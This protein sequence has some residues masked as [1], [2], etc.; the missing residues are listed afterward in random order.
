MAIGLLNDSIASGLD[1]CTQ[2]GVLYNDGALKL[3]L[4]LVFLLG[5]HRPGGSG[6]GDGD[7]D[8]LDFII[9]V[10]LVKYKE[11]LNTLDL[12][13]DFFFSYSYHIMTRTTELFQKRIYFKESNQ[14]WIFEKLPAYQCLDRISIS[15]KDIMFTLIARRSR[16]FAG[17]RKPINVLDVLLKVAF[18]ALRL[19]EFYS[20]LDVLLKVAFRAPPT[21]YSL[22]REVIRSMV[23]KQRQL[24]NATPLDVKSGSQFPV[25]ESGS[26]HGNE[27]SLTCESE[28][29]NLR[30]THPWYLRYIMFQALKL[31]VA[32]IQVIQTMDLEWLS[33]SGNLSDESQAVAVEAAS[34]LSRRIDAGSVRKWI[35]P[36]WRWF[37][38]SSSP[39]APLCASSPGP[40]PVHLAPELLRP[41]L[42]AAGPKLQ[43]RSWAFHTSSSSSEAAKRRASREAFFPVYNKRLRI[44]GIL[45]EC[46]NTKKLGLKLLE[47]DVIMN[48]IW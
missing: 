45:G 30:Y 20:V 36:S 48:F 24:L 41:R 4:P 18:R 40:S 13:K 46:Y 38:S 5:L 39:M 15:A 22:Q 10:D 37:L 17:T 19:T 28:V 3:L 43:R 6:R 35:W 42:Q 47:V 7:E 26:V 29:S 21:R 2:A 34:R 11:I 16:H 9:D 14:D 44:W 1:Q 27:I 23:K 25:L 12:R 33:T 8:P 32:F 31:K